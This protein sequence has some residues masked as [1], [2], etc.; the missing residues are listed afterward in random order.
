[1]YRIIPA[2]KKIKLNIYIYK[3]IIYYL[4]M[5]KFKIFFIVFIISFSYSQEIICIIYI[6]LICY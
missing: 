5:N 6:E 2:Y 4:M 3:Y 1:M